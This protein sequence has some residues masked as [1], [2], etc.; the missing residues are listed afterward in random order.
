MSER[1]SLLRRRIA[2][3]AG[4]AFT[5]GAV[6]APSPAAL[7]AGGAPV[8]VP[9]EPPPGV[10][11]QTAMR[12]TEGQLPAGA[13][14]V[15]QQASGAFVPRPDAPEAP[16][17]LASESTTA[18]APATRT[19]SRAQTTTVATPAAPSVAQTA[20]WRDARRPAPE[21]TRAPK[22]KPTQAPAQRDPA[23][24]IP[25]FEKLFRLALPVATRLPPP[26]RSSLEIAWLL[27]A[28]ALLAGAAA[29]GAVTGL[30]ARRLA[31]A[32]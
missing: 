23:P 20:R 30:V 18:T 24:V 1:A 2:L 32:A 29:G 22:S 14:V 12:P 28:A 16:A 25:R 5:C 10:R 31:G 26:D 11:I 13:R 4:A 19:T 3:C 15:E 27:A 17:R 7:A 9:D 8:P 21:Q 6:L